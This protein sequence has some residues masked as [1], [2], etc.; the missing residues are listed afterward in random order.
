MDRLGRRNNVMILCTSNPSEIIDSAFM[1][2]VG[3][4]QSIDLSGR[5]SS[6]EYFTATSMHS[7]RPK[8]SISL[9]QGKT[10]E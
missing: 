9:G 5:G 1:S 8:G 10:L 6:Y 2:R 3:M 7:S 4:V